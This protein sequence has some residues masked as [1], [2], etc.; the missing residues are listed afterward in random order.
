MSKHAAEHFARQA[1]LY[2]DHAHAAELSIDPSY[3]HP[4]GLPRASDPVQ[5]WGKASARVA[6]HKAHKRIPQ[7]G[8]VVTMD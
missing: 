6:D 3:R 7:R 2:P 4:L 8:K 5:A 1:K